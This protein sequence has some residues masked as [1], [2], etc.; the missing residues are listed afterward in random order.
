MGSEVYVLVDSETGLIKCDSH[1]QMLCIFAT[2]DEAK[3]HLKRAPDE[4]QKNVEIVMRY[5][6]WSSEP[7][8]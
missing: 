1:T 8:Q 3:R 7:K 4:D 5:P 6:N 2:E